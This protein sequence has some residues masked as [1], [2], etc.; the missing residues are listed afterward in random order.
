M[1]KKKFFKTVRD[2]EVTFEC[3]AP[4]AKSVEL[5]CESNGWQ[6]IAMGRRR[7]GAFRARLRLPRDQQFQFRYRVDGAAWT[8]DEAADAYAPND[9]GTENGVVV[10]RPPD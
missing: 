8:N 1:I 5:L 2:C 9:F 7:G 3:A 4:A 10:T 6:P